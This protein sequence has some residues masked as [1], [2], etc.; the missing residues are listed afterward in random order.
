MH[1]KR[2]MRRKHRSPI[3]RS[4]FDRQRHSL[5]CLACAIG[6]SL[7]TSSAFAQTP[8]PTAPAIAGPQ[9]AGRPPRV[10]S[11]MPPP[12]TTGLQ[13]QPTV[14]S[15]GGQPSATNPGTLQ[16][17]VYNTAKP[18]PGMAASSLSQP[19]ASLASLTTQID[20]KAGQAASLPTSQSNPLTEEFKD[21][22][23]ICVVGE[24]RILA[25][26]MRVLIEE[27]I[28]KNRS[29]IN[30][31]QERELRVQLTR[32][33]LAQYVEI[34][35][36]Y[37]E[38][39]REMS[40]NAAPK[41]LKEA[42]QKISTRA[43]KIFYEKQV[44]ALLKKHDARD[45]AMLEQK[46][47][48]KSVSILLLK[49]QFMERVM[50]QQ[51]EQSKV[52]E[53]YDIDR[54]D[55]L[56]YYEEHQSDWV[57]PATTRW[58]QLTI[59]F[60]KHPTRSEAEQ[61]I[62]DLGNEVFL[63]GKPFTAVAKQRSEGFNASSGGEYDWT[64]KGS[65][66]SAKLDEAIFS[67]PI[68]KL[69]P[70]IEDEV[71]MHIVEVLERKADHTV[72]FE[73]AQVDIRKKLSEQKRQ[74]EIEKFREQVMKRTTVWTKWPEDIPGSKSLVEALGDTPHAMGNDTNE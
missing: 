2:K 10:V 42:K 9:P 40:G 57:R 35:A 51:L 47:R 38:F 71:G 50:A 58:R 8:W 23:L 72:S 52:R 26:D 55:L 17:P 32:Q 6:F 62:I 19:A 46:L 41:E 36:M 12:K 15:P 25:G 68:G 64:T 24:E 39:L 31:T 18:L 20:Q 33:A 37:Q 14:S 13:A 49:N 60:D 27:V 22:Q 28:E 66:K 30:P 5:R 74:Q 69:S 45:L 1:T 7:G 48:E 43:N 21:G 4:R 44:P 67:Y 54:D 16:Y 70:I 53:E 34:K 59:R 61:L 65:L 63:G 73:D 29:R 3:C 56:K 11:L